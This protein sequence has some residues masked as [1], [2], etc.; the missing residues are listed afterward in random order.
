M[1]TLINFYHSLIFIKSRFNQMYSTASG[2]EIA[3]TTDESD[4]QYAVDQ[5]GNLFDYIHYSA[6][7]WLLL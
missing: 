5:A 3:P 2:K 7:L 4:I 6:I 1:G